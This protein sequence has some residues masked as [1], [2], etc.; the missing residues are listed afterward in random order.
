MYTFIFSVYVYETDAILNIKIKADTYIE[1][2]QKLQQQIKT[3]IIAVNGDPD[4]QFDFHCFENDAFDIFKSEIQEYQQEMPLAIGYTDVFIDNES[5][6]L[7]A[8]YF[9][10]D[11]EEYEDIARLSFENLEKSGLTIADAEKKLKSEVTCFYN[12]EDEE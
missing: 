7:I 11:T 4:T 1:A 5:Q 9:N 3:F 2:T 6:Q 8:A 12:D 10:P